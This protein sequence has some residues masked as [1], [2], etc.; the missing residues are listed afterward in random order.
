MANVYARRMYREPSSAE[1]KSASLKSDPSAQARS[2]I[3]RRGAVRYLSRAN[4]SN[5]PLRSSLS[6]QTSEV[7]HHDGDDV[8]RP[9][10]QSRSPD[11]DSTI[12]EL[13]PMLLRDAIRHNRPGRRMRI[14]R[15]SNLRFE[16][17]LSS[18]ASADRDTPTTRPPSD[19]PLYTPRFAPALA[20]HG[21]VR[22]APHPDVI[23]TQTTFP[24]SET[25]DERSGL[26]TFR[27]RMGLH[28]P[29]NRSTNE[30]RGSASPH[31]PVIDGLGDRERSAS[32]DDDDQEQDTWET[33][34][35]TITPDSTL[36]SADSSFT[37][38]AA[39]ASSTHTSRSARSGGEAATNQPTTM[40]LMLD[41]YPDYF[42]PC[43][44][45]DGTTDSD[46]EADSSSQRPDVSEVRRRAR[47]LLHNLALGMT[48]DNQPP[49]RRLPPIST[50]LAQASAP[51]QMQGIADR[52]ARR[53]DIPDSWWAV[54]GLPR[55]ID[56]SSESSNRG[57]NNDHNNNEL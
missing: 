48:Q 46:T 52:L 23:I 42:N 55:M 36:P 28:R 8:S 54:A 22:Y 29:E 50:V 44:S 19:E 51:D 39:A 43:D 33:L 57:L 41:P 25:Q 49:A 1:A 31:R 40:H 6:R 10:R 12:R 37:S 9:G 35:T 13:G 14:P 45:P 20:Y 53:D 11:P 30:T 21:E 15:E 18:S 27:R 26:R 16:M 3:R 34:L 2:S 24:R 4:G 47:F 56:R 17:P 38:N 5:A 7:Y 32:P